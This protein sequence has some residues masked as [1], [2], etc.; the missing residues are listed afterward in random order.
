MS[1]IDLRHAESEAETALCFPVMAQLRPRLHD[2]AAF[3]AQVARQ[4]GAGYRLLA[5]WYSDAPVALAGY[6]VEENLIHGRFIYVDDLVTDAGERG[7]GLGARLLDAVAQE[8]HRLGCDRLV[9]D[10]ALD[11]VRA[12]RFYY[13]QGLLAR[14]LRFSREI[15]PQ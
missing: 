13:R 14:A 5:A 2:A 6:R 1:G 7:G 11:N 9:L 3:V 8:G 12:H 15:A 4:R 10:T